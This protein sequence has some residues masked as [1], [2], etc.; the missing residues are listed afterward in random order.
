MIE[1]VF[2]IGLIFLLA[3]RYKYEIEENLK[4]VKN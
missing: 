1:V 3:D 2:F 4:L